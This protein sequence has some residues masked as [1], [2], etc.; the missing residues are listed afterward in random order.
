MAV[1]GSIVINTDID[2]KGFEEGVKDLKSRLSG[3]NRGVSGLKT[4]LEKAFSGSTRGISAF[5]SKAKALEGT[6]S[7]VKQKMAALSDK[8]VKSQAFLDLEKESQKVDAQLQKLIEKQRKMEMLGTDFNKKG[9]LSN[10]WKNAEYDAE[11]LEKRFH[12]I[13]DRL[14]EMRK[15]GQEFQL[16]SD[17]GE[18]V[19]L[20]QRLREL[21]TLY[22]QLKQKG[23]EL[24]TV[25][26][27]M[28]G[29]KASSL[30]DAFRSAMPLTDQF[31][32]RIEGVK[33]AIA[34]IG[35]AFATGGWKGAALQGLNQLL[36]SVKNAA[37]YAGKA[38]LK[39]F[40]A[41]VKR[42]IS[43][44]GSAVKNLASK[45]KG[46][47]VSA[48]KNAAKSLTGM[49]KGA[50]DAGKGLSGLTK[51]LTG[52]TSM[53]KRMLL[54]R[55][56]MAMLNAAK[57]GM[58][59]LAQVSPAFNQAMSQ[60]KGSLSQLKNSFASAFGSIL[61]IVL[62]V[63]QTLIGWLSTA[64]NYVAQFFTALSGGK[65]FKKAVAVQ[66]DYAASLGNT[67]SAAKEAKNELLAFDKITKLSDDSSSGGGGG[68]GASPS[69]MFED[70]EINSSISEFVADLK[71]AWAAEDFTAVGE[72]IGNKI[73]EMVEQIDQ[74]VSWDN[75]G[76]KITTW[77]SNLADV[78]NSL[79]DTIKWDKIGETIGH[80]LN[81]ITY[82]IETFL[83]KFDLDKI[84]TAL[85]E[86]AN[87]L[88]KGV[89]WEALGRTVAKALNEIT[90]GINNFANGA[91]WKAIGS[92]FAKSVNSLLDN[93]DGNAL[94]EALSAKFRIGLD[95][96]NGFVNEF[97][98]ADLGSTLSDVVDGW[99]GSIDWEELGSTIA[100]GLN[101][102]SDTLTTF[103]TETNW[104]EKGDDIGTAISALV[105]GIDGDK[106]G[107]ALAGPFNALIGSVDGFL[108]NFEK[109]DTWKD[110]GEKIG[111][112]INSWF[113]TIDWETAAKNLTKGADG[114]VDFIKKAFETIKW[115]EIGTKLGTLINGVFHI[116]WKNVGETVSKGI[117]GILDFLIEAVKTVEWEQF[118]QSVVD[119][120]SSIE[121]DELFSKAGTLIADLADGIGLVFKMAWNACIDA[122]IEKA[123]DWMKEYL[124]ILKFQDKDMKDKADEWHE[125]LKKAMDNAFE[126][127]SDRE[128]TLTV[129]AKEKISGSMATIE[130]SWKAIDSKN[131]ELVA[132]AKEKVKGA[133]PE[134][135]T[136]WK[137]IMDKSPQM[138]AEA[139]EKIN[140][141]LAALKNN[142][143][144]VD[145][146]DPVLAAE[147]KEKV[148]GAL[149][150]LKDAWGAIK[151]KETKTVTLEADK[152]KNFDNNK[153]DFDKLDSKTAKAE[154]L[155]EKGQT[156]DSNKKTYDDLGSK[157]A[158]AELLA[159]KS[160]NFD[161]IK[162]DYDKIDNKNVK[163]NAA[164]GDSVQKTA[165]GWWSKIVG[166]FKSSDSY[167]KT[168]G[169]LQVSATQTTDKKGVSSWWDKL[170]GFWGS[171]SLSVT[172]AMTVTSAELKKGLVV[173]GNATVD[174][175]TGG[176]GGHYTMQ[177]GGIVTH[178]TRALV[179]ENG[180]EAVIPL[181][182]NTEWL[183]I[184]G[185]YVVN[186]L[187][188]LASGT[189][190]PAN[191][192]KTLAILG[193]NK[194]ETEVVSPLSTMRQAVVE[195]LQQI[196][197]TGNDNQTINLTLNL[198]GTAIYNNVVKINRQ[199]T[200]AGGVNPLVV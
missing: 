179:G 108:K 28:S 109:N 166:W 57:E 127:L 113:K 75:V 168:K 52:I 4:N 54:R 87:G 29:F 53:L 162:K 193:D 119:F 133:L 174:L 24:N 40:G 191:Y 112:A 195:A 134:L 103:F 188:Q 182:N 69:A 49:K 180:P 92:D 111:K 138:S 151:D 178:P 17:T 126:G 45:L 194:R 176:N 26:G 2:P 163:V 200:R 27:Q 189:V 23:A 100:T 20:A 95:L 34:R 118:G 152:G 123:P 154:L 60:L 177:T 146:K 115:S 96:A 39:A 140:G 93:I 76:D 68:G 10:A 102:I 65:T 183:D 110:A 43:A 88:D 77:V 82:T 42:A 46:A 31:K 187:P 141:A 30:G 128:I 192:G 190:I 13:A 164:L 167:Q 86:I 142:W 84:G 173:K 83:D 184:V 25:T 81:T 99:F 66:E 157:Q 124:G 41:G 155:A 198:D 36:G 122:L 59:N 72:I 158:K 148:Q 150:T 33:N 3:L 172:G 107:S 12:E 160:K 161:S 135:E 8:P 125:N 62:P 185:K 55:A 144:A 181:K 196:G 70:A 14:E 56:L 5:Q 89:D 159:E 50:A 171:K 44:I 9:D 63:L 61:P 121:W 15:N 6:I 145:N 91:D 106:I 19:T 116:D 143:D 64:A 78:F 21:E 156:F 165:T 149:A 37:Q 147:A 104:E 197:L 120:F 1:D 51:K 98:W 169:K 18:Y 16:G 170:K 153:K 85:A 80:G 35:E 73:N 47:L 114:I 32:S 48:A 67:A 137:S 175:K 117:G 129:E 38:L 130:K 101:G 58:Q 186:N 105:D 132:E 131:P 90:S 94:G 97:H 199:R 139:K 71:A 7:E 79:M 22:D 11:I 74:L 136:Q